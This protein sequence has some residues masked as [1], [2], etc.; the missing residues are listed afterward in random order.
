MSDDFS[1]RWEI[2]RTGLAKSLRIAETDLRQ[3][4]FDY[5]AEQVARARRRAMLQWPEGESPNPM[6]PQPQEDYPIG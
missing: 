1:R 6:P 5:E 3:W 4:G 2:R